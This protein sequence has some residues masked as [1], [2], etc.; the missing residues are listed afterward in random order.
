MY[1]HIGETIIL[2]TNDIIAIVDKDNIDLSPEKMA[3]QVHDNSFPL[4]K[5]DGYKSVVVTDKKLYLSPF[6]SN[7]LKKRIY[8]NYF[9]GAN[10]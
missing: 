4:L 3:G 8:D 9:Q 2:R 5:S 6:S 10:K 7:T 1:V